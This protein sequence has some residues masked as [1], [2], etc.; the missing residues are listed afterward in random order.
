MTANPS[1]EPDLMDP[2]LVADPRGGYGRLREQAPVLRGRAMDGSPAWYVTRQQDV[3]TVLGD[4]RF[5][6]SAVSVPGVEVD[7][8]RDHQLEMLG[9]P[10]DLTGYLTDTILDLDGADH[11]RLRKLVARAFTV[12]RVADLRPRV[13]E[14]ADLLLD[15]L[16]E[17]VDLIESFAY[18]L[19]ITV[20]C[21]L[22]GVPE[23]DRPAWRAWST[24]LATMNPQTVPGAVRDMVE[25]VRDLVGRRRAAPAE[26]LL[27]GL[28]HAQDENG[29]RLTDAELVAMVFTLVIA[30]HETTAHL[31]GNG[32]VALLAHPDQLDLLRRD[33][34]R[35]PAA[36]H[37]LLRWCGPVQ[38]TRLR[39]AAADVELGGVRIRAGEAV[40][41]VLVSANFDPRVYADPDRFD[42]TR[43]PS[44]RGD[45]HV[46]FGHGAH[47]CLG[48]ALARQEAEVA[49]RALFT[50]FPDLTLVVD[51]PAW[52]QIPGVR[53]LTELPVRLR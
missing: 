51:E 14:I 27:S 30:G 9:V 11:I 34:G 47:Y 33:P 16:A 41:A 48:A 3:R 46:G 45:G 4:H 37:E 36:V 19:P 50:R 43:R 35:W 25:H 38:V 44:G 10:R 39:Y 5:V 26:D 2:E 40:Q 53:R 28:V 1:V 15:R 49:L 17:P 42:V 29:D 21:E 6:T 7:T 32:T 18:P 12:R 13:E 20:I 8:V 22:V 31:I 52:A 24:A 23:A